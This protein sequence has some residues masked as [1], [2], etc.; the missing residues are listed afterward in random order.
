MAT[1][2]IYDRVPTVEECNLTAQ[3]W[4]ITCATEIC[5]P[6]RSLPQTQDHIKISGYN[7]INFHALK[8]SKSVSKT[9]A[10]SL[11]KAGKA[12]GR[13]GKTVIKSAADVAALESKTNFSINLFETAKKMRHLG[14]QYNPSSF[15]ALILKMR[16]PSGAVLVFSTGRIVCTGPKK[17]L[18]ATYLLNYT[19][20]LLRKYGYPGLRIKPG[21]WS[22]ENI[23][24]DASI[25]HKINLSV[26]YARHSECC[27][28]EPSIFPGVTFRK[29]CQSPGSKGIVITLLIYGSG[30]LVITGAKKEGYI[31]DALEECLPD[32][33]DARVRHKKRPITSYSP[34]APHGERD[35]KKKR[36]IR[37]GV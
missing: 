16:Q 34:N 27:N 24:A 21:T 15:H 17:Q 7:P 25:S 10:G 37:I 29:T 3:N 4:V 36:E 5:S 28:Y 35:T 33:W 11:K 31:R 26:F 20:S 23:V 1:T 9:T 32:I 12:S 18:V 2:H 22:V 19:V 14:V 6:E 8:K 13:G 30:K